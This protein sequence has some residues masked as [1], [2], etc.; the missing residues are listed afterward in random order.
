MDSFFVR[1]KG[2]NNKKCITVFD[3]NTGNITDYKSITEMPLSDRIG[4]VLTSMSEY[5][6]KTI[7]ADQIEIIHAAIK[8]TVLHGNFHPGM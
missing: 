3:S 6:E 2:F 1:S 8:Q 4:L 7:G 5:D